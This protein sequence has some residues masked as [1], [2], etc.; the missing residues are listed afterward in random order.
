MATPDS[1]RLD[2]GRR[3]WEFTVRH[4]DSSEAGQLAAAELGKLVA[5]TR[6]VMQEQ[7]TVGE[8]LGRATE[9]LGALGRPL[10]DALALIAHFGSVAALRRRRRDLRVQL[11]TRPRLPHAFVAEARSI[12][13]LALADETLLLHYGMSRDL[14]PRLARD[15]DRFEAALAR[16]DLAEE[17]IRRVRADLTA[18]GQEMYVLIRRLDAVYRPRFAGDPELLAVWTQARAIQEHRGRESVA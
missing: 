5:A 13:R 3:A 1:L 7:L 6:G 10:R 16:R 12:Q 8:A 11:R 4:P 18:I 2:A 17:G 15:L 9:E 14:L